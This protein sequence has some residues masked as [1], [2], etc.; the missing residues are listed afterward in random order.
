VN[1]AS[2]TQY[3]AVCF[4]VQQ[5]PRPP[6]KLPSQ[7]NR[8]R[9]PPLIGFG[10]AADTTACARGSS[11]SD[12]HRPRPGHRRDR[13]SLPD[14]TRPLAGAQLPSVSPAVLFYTSGIVPVRK[15]SVGCICDKPRV[16]SLMIETQLNSAPRT[17]L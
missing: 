16:F 17:G 9:P 10:A 8:A 7:F 5:H 15:C 3:T 2:A 13:P 1:V 14:L 12:H 11:S 6:M 4:L